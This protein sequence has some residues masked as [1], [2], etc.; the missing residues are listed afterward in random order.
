MLQKALFT[1]TAVVFALLGIVSGHS[2]QGQGAAKVDPQTQGSS[3]K[4]ATAGAKA[5]K[6][7]SP[8]TDGITQG[9]HTKGDLAAKPTT[10]IAEVSAEKR[11]AV[12]KKLLELYGS[13]EGM[14]VQMTV[15]TGTIAMGV[16]VD[17]K[18]GELLLDR[19]PC[20]RK[21]EIFKKPYRSTPLGK[22]L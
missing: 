18:D 15:V 7:S 16:I 19:E 2:T 20:N 9:L 14:T 3:A 12:A 10:M 1:V 21:V 8:Q 13:S 11:A 5:T 4:G 22:K 17:E 6:E